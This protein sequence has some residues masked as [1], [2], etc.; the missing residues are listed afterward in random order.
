M[1][2]IDEQ[3]IRDIILSKRGKNKGKLKSAFPSPHS[4][5]SELSKRA[6]Y[7]W[8]LARFHGGIDT[9]LPIMA[10]IL[11]RKDPEKD[12]LNK[13]ADIIA[14]ESFGTD[15]AAALKWANIL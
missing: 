15:K 13:F 14:I 6:Y 1:L 10:E 11:I 2:M 7:V 9:T 3:A 12:E 8:R 4:T 5:D